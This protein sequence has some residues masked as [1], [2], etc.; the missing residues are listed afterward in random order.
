MR[1][2]ISLPAIPLVLL[3]LAPA[4]G[5]GGGSSNPTL[6]PPPAGGEVWGVVGCSM[7]RASVGGYAM[8]GGQLGWSITAINDY[9]GGDIDKWA[10]LGDP[11]WLD[12]QSA[13]AQFGAEK[14]WFQPCVRQRTDPNPT[15]DDIDDVEIIVDQIANLAPGV[16]I[17]VSAFPEYIGFF[18]PKTGPAG[19]DVSQAL[20]DHLVQ[21]GVAQPGPLVG[22]LELSQTIDN[23]CGLND[24]GLVFVGNQL[25]AFFG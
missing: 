17:F 6:P 12:F 7:T 16:P 25:L 22:P 15:A 2:T 24:A 13:L 1:P 9:P 14:I 23:M 19:P 5:G 20:A 11:R 18:C 21:T 3:L 8:V 4:C 10:D